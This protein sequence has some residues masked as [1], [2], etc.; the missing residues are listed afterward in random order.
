MGLMLSKV[1][2]TGRKNSDF[3]IFYFFSDPDIYLLKESG[4]LSLFVRVTYL[5]NR[6]T[7]FRI[8]LTWINLKDIYISSCLKWSHNAG[9][10]YN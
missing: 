2:Q 5:K 8:T 7:R 10:C 6:I 4:N 9:H 1:G 3:F